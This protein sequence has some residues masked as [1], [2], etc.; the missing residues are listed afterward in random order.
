MMSA[1][2]YVMLKIGHM[3]SAI[4]YVMLKIDHK[5]SNIFSTCRN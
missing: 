3:M 1:I 4:G 2:G 5:V